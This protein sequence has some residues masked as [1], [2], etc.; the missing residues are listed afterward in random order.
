MNFKNLISILFFG[1]LLLTGCT[2]EADIVPQD[3]SLNGTW[4]LKNL[5][6]GFAGINENYSNGTIT[7][8]FNSQNQNIVIVNNNEAST[9]F[10]YAS[11]T[12]NYSII[13]INNQKY[14]QID[15]GEYGGLN[16][17]NNNLVIDQDIISNGVGAD[18]FILNFEKINSSQ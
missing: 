11:G 8:T 1:L 10:I 6:G 4:N 14:L 17:S 16:I 5:S 13:E 12:Y 9:Q 2:E 7:W 15:N 18:G 3:Q